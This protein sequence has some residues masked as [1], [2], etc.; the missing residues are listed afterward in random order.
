MWLPAQMWLAARTW[1]L[2]RTR[3]RVIEGER[4][5]APKFGLE[6]DIAST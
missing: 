6:A 1:L 2:A 4:V 5:T 3:A